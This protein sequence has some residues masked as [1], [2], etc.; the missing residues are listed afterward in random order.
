[1]NKEIT[2]IIGAL[3]IGL[4]IYFK[5][6]SEIERREITLNITDKENGI[7]AEMYADGYAWGYSQ[8]RLQMNIWRMEGKSEE[9]IKELIWDWLK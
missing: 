1:M 2:I 5:P 9:L 6:T 3:I 7:C 4:A 8:V